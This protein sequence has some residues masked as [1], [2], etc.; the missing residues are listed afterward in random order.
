MIVKLNK[1]VVYTKYEDKVLLLNL[2]EKNWIKISSDAFDIICNI[3]NLEY[4]L[5]VEKI[6]TK[7]SVEKKSAE[8][9]I[10]SL[11]KSN[12]FQY[13]DNGSY[14]KEI[15]ESVETQI[16]GHCYLHVSSKCNLNCGYCS[17][18]ANYSNKKDLSTNELKKLLRKLSM[19]KVQQLVFSGGEPLLREDLKELVLYAKPLFPELGIVTNCTLVDES[20]A[21]FIAKYFT[22]IQ[23]S[24]D[25]GNA[26]VHDS[27]RGK[28]SFK[29][30]VRGIKFLKSYNAQQIKITPTINRKNYKD[31]EKIVTLAKQLDV[32]LGPRFVT[33][34]GRG[35]TNYSEYE[36]DDSII[37]EAYKK[38][39][40][41]CKQEGYSKYSIKHFFSET[42]NP[43][44]GCGICKSQICVDVNGDIYPCAYLMSNETK[45][46]NVFITEPI[47]QQIKKNK[48]GRQF[49]DGG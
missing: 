13:D 47:L 38:I 46:G 20:N 5:A 15:N 49:M 26:Q 25:S 24:I 7:Y 3:N 40:K 19:N 42:M 48:L 44:V 11:L 23:V 8:K 22:K 18:N 2:R 27:I 43:K 33:P 41:M 9:F 17:I 14:M 6:Q 16:I 39:W 45:V 10:L 12:I 1:N 34:S 4:M 32:Y 37:I 28:G 29:R 36:I 35:A 30:S 31:I 21:E